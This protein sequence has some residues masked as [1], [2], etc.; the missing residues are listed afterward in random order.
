MEQTVVR[1]KLEGIYKIIR[2]VFMISMSTYFSI[3]FHPYSA[4][5]LMWLDGFNGISMPVNTGNEFEALQYSLTITLSLIVYWI[6]IYNLKHNIIKFVKRT[7]VPR[8]NS[9]QSV[10]PQEPIKMRF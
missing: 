3:W 6:G 1:L 9:T 8:G 2:R 4:K 10:L 5:F 7:I